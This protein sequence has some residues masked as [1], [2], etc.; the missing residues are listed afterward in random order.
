MR[1]LYSLTAPFVSRLTRSDGILS[2]DILQPAETEE[3]TPPFISDASREKIS[4]CHHWSSIPNELAQLDA[5]EVTHAPVIRYTHGSGIVGPDGFA[6]GKKRLRLEPTFIRNALTK[7]V[8]Q[9]SEVTYINEMA[10]HLYFGHW[11]KEGVSQTYLTEGDRYYLSNPAT[12]THCAQYRTALGLRARDEHYVIADHVITYSDFSQ[13]SLKRERYEKM[14]AQLAA[15]FPMTEETHEKVFMW[16]GNEGESR[17][18]HKADEVRDKLEADGWKTLDVTL[19]LADLYKALSGAK[20]VASMEGSHLNHIYFCTQPDTT[21]VILVPHDRFNTM[22]LGL[23]RAVGNSIGICVLA[24][25]QGNG[26]Q[27]D[28]DAFAEVIDQTFATSQRTT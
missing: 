7:P 23:A 22:P 13:G 4:G 24:G 2:K 10:T 26:Y 15:A 18:F 5:R 9:T 20:I 12:W 17:N 28:F 6:T 21:Q 1:R 11:L 3:V 27:M 16:R 19:P 25:D 8:T 14:R